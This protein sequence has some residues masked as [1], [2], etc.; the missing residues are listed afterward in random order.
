M[1]CCWVLIYVCVVVLEVCGGL[2]GI[3]N[4]IGLVL[5]VYF[6][7]FGLLIFV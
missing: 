6:D 3:T 5:I 2:F 4:A 7:L 1:V